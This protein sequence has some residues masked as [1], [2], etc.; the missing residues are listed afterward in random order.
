MPNEPFERD[1]SDINL[2]N[3]FWKDLEL[4]FDA[5]EISQEPRDP[6]GISVD[7]QV[8]EMQETFLAMIRNNLNP[9][10]RYMKA[11][12]GE[13]AREIYEISE[14]VITPLISKIE[15]VG[16]IPHAEDLTFFRSLLLLALGETDQHA[17]VKLQEVV[18]EGF[19]E[20]EKRFKLSCRGYRKAV[21]NLVE[22]YRA[23]KSVDS[24]TE[25]DVKLLF[26]VGIPSL[27]WVKKM[28]AHEL[29]TLTGITEEKIRKV[30]EISSHGFMAMKFAAAELARDS[31]QPVTTNPTEVQSESEPQPLQEIVK[32]E[33]L[34]R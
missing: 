1:E 28:K 19:S 30:K 10:S 14:L 6:N 22:L 11:L 3:H 33:L 5:L 16:L 21:R 13:D 31:F 26:A 15:Q 34:G 9:I 4:D 20:V 24:I 8:R 27:S 23:V 29:S 12:P 18:L 17:K 32:Y 25:N 2:D 7:P